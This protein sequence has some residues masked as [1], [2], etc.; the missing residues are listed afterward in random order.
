VVVIGGLLLIG[1]LGFLAVFG[2]HVAAGNFDGPLFFMGAAFLLIE[3]RGIVDLSLLFGSTW[4]VNSSVI[5]GI[6]F[7]AY[8]ANLYVSK[9]RPERVLPYFGLL[10]AAL[11]LNY[12]VRPSVL[13]AL[14]LSARGALGGLLNALPVFFA[15]IIFSTLFANSEHPSAS[16]G[17]NLLG[18]VVGGCLE[19]LS[20]F[21]G[22]KSLSLVALMLYLAALLL[23]QRRSSRMNPAPI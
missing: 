14:N 23:L 1:T 6:L 7:M 15:G 11:L 18:A 20:M 21:I 4:I 3:T 17:S 9:R 2:R 12:F 8:L 13:L 19:Y 16:L 10:W 22:L 5:A